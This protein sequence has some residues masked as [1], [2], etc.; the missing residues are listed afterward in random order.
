MAVFLCAIVVAVSAQ[1]RGRAT[2]NATF[3]KEPGGIRLGSLITGVSYPV[4]RSSGSHR[5]LTLEG[6]IPAA[7]AEATTRDGFDLVVTAG[8]GERLRAEPGGA[9]IGRLVEGTLVTRL[10]TRGTWVRV[11]RLGWVSQNTLGEPDPAEVAAALQGGVTSG[12]STAAAAGTPPPP[13]PPAAQVSPATPPPA[14]SG[15]LARPVSPAIDAPPNGKVSGAATLRTGTAVSLTPDGKPLAVLPEAAEVE[16]VERSRD[17]VRVRMDGWVRAADVAEL[18]DGPRITGAMVRS[19]PDRFVGETVTWRLQFLAVQQADALRPE[20]PEGQPYV[21]A[22]G[23]LPESGFTYLMVTP[24]QAA[25]FR[26]LSPLDEVEVEAVVRA[27]RTK[28]LPTPVLQLVK[29]AR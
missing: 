10:G 23:P 17:W 16:V 8:A 1:T 4:G 20:I 11:R 24:E 26:R 19:E 13:G 28:F 21:L 2:A 14:A 18:A 5:E 25:Q 29:V 22:R 12:A 15:P 3:Q 7:S 6:W 27:G 9:V